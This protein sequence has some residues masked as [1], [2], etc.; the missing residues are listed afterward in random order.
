MTSARAF[1]KYF[2]FLLSEE[3]RKKSERIVLNVAIISFIA[4]LFLILLTDF[5]ILYSGNENELLSSPIAAIYTPFSFILIYEVYLLIFYLPKSF[6]TY[7]GKQY[8][9]IVLIII[10]RLFKDFSSLSLTTDWFKIKY[11]LQFTYDLIASLILFY[12]IYLFRKEG[13][14]RFVPEVLSHAEA[15]GVERFIKIKKTIASLLIPL[16]F[17]VSVYSFLNWLWITLGTHQGGVNAFRNINNVFFEH[18]FTILIVVDVVLLLF[19]FFHTDEFHKIIRNS[20][21]IISTILIRL[22]FSVEGLL[23]TLLIVAAIVF[24]LLMLVIYNKYESRV[25]RNTAL[26]AVTEES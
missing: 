15:E 9:I 7:I 10:R 19:S 18:F 17:V 4:H 13:A 11:D 16:I 26:D 8:E 12:L 20:G 21:F 5:G 25:V 24:G 3:S 23:N 1:S 6:T 14:K 22:S 2:N